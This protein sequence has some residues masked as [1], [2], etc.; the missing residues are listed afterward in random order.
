MTRITF[1]GNFSEKGC[2][3]PKQ[4]TVK[5]GISGTAVPKFGVA[6]GS[7]GLITELANEKDCTTKVTP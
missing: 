2:F 5:F 1:G 7:R 4:K 6:D 3:C